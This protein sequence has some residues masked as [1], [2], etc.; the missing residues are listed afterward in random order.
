MI[1]SEKSFTSYFLSLY[2]PSYRNASPNGPWPWIDL[3][4]DIDDEELSP[5]TPPSR[6]P[7][8]KWP[9]YPQSLFPNWTQQQV[10]RSGISKALMERSDGPCTIYHVDVLDTGK[11]Q[12]AGE[13]A[14]CDQNKDQLWEILQT[15]V[16][17][18]FY[19]FGI[20]GVVELNTS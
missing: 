10:D 1:Q 17:I 2:S 5:T 9:H 12:R 20:H 15:G 13:L 16:I 11:F 19:S 8:L 18:L 7:T 14:I 3:D 4:S 6:R